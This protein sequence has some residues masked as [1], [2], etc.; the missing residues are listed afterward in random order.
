[1]LVV[2]VCVVVVFVVAVVAVALAVDV[3]RVLFVV[4]CSLCVDRCGFCFC[5]YAC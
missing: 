2:V 1:M 5:R 3:G 4:C